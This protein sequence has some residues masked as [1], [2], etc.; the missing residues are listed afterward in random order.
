MYFEEVHFVKTPVTGGSYSGTGDILASVVCGN[1][2]NGKG[3]T[4]AVE[5]A[6][7]FINR[8]IED[9]YKDKTDRNDGINFE[10]YLYMLMEDVQKCQ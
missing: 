4:E 9:T 2:V 10:K 7:K 8:A 1:V 5:I 3:L 6:V